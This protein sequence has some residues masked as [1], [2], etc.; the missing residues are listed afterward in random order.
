MT[1]H[2]STD[3]LYRITVKGR[4][5]FINARGEIVMEPRFQECGDM[6]EGRIVFRSGDKYGLID[7][8]GNIVSPAVWDAAKFWDWS[9]FL[10][11][12]RGGKYG[13][14]DRH[15]DVRIEPQF[16]AAW[17]F[18]DGVAA[19]NLGMRCD[20]RGLILEDGLW[21]YIDTAGAFLIPPRFSWASFFIEGLAAVS[22][23]KGTGFIDMQGRTAIDRVFEHAGTFHEGLANVQEKGFHGFIDRSGKFVIP[24]IFYD[25]WGH[26][27]EGLAPVMLES[28]GGLWGY[29]DRENRLVI[30]P[31]FANAWDFEDGLAL[32]T[33]SKGDGFIN[34]EGLFVVAPGKFSEPGHFSEGLAPARRGVNGKWGF[35]NRTGAFAIPPRFDAAEWF[36]N[37]LARVNIGATE[38]HLYISE[39]GRWGYINHSGDWVWKPSD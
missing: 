38:S 32:V 8:R 3:P 1:N 20:D 17:E 39:G 34:R 30:L 12:R 36:R 37:G 13:Y 6:F 16:D 4:D 35:I 14:I 5:G 28:P 15:G 18:L 10:S 27:S 29:I 33:V 11:V 25:S 23:G 21:G 19:V 7:E 22:L 31:R 26:F 9:G 24:P 2:K